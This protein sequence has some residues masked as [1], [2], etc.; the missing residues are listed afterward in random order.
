MN[1]PFYFADSKFPGY[2]IWAG[3][4]P[5]GTT[6][7]EIRERIKASLVVEDEGHLFKHIVSVVV[8]SARAHSMASYVTITVEGLAFAQVAQLQ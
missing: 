4:L 3:D 2:K 6:L 5:S 1:K 8:K 7:D